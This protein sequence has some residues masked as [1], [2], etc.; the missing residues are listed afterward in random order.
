MYLYQHDQQARESQILSTTWGS[1][2]YLRLAAVN[3]RA[4][5]SHPVYNSLTEADPY[6]TP[7]LGI[8]CCS[9]PTHWL[10]DWQKRRKRKSPSL[11]QFKMFYS[12]TGN[13]WADWHPSWSQDVFS[14]RSSATTFTVD[15]S[16]VWDTDLSVFPG[17]VQ[18]PLCPKG[19]LTA[20]GSSLISNTTLASPI[21]ALLSQQ[22]RDN[23]LFQGERILTQFGL[24]LGFPIQLPLSLVFE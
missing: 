4:I 18:L 5:A 20:C 9:Q 24:D 16:S 17:T 15:R 13:S 14:L 23:L 11:L 8:V 1:Q 22:S 12:K 19:M 6:P 10:D 7:C 3:V 21:C 2:I